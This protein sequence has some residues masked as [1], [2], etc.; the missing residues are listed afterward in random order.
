MA[1]VICCGGE[2]EMIRR[3]LEKL[4]SFKKIRESYVIP[5]NY[6]NEGL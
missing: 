3:L 6:T 5:S 1:G 4:K 2:R